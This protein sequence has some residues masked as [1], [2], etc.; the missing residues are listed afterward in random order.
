M[1][2]KERISHFWNDTLG[3]DCPDEVNI[4]DSERPEDKELRESLERIDNLEK[5]YEASITSSAKGGKG[6]STKV[7]EKVE[8][9]TSK[10]IKKAEEKNAEQKDIDIREER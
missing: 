9:N 8:T 7:V 2:L 10:A 3:V 5:K 1:K 4:L 6:S